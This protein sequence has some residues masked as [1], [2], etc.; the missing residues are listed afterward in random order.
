MT[1]QNRHQS[2]KR[3]TIGFVA[4]ADF[5]SSLAQEL[6][7][8]ID[9]AA[10]ELDVN[11]VAFSFGFN[12]TLAN[13]YTLAAYYKNLFPFINKYNIDALVTWGST[14]SYIMPFEDVEKF[15]HDMS[16]MP[17]ACMGM[18]IEGVPSLVIDN[19]HGI[20]LLMSHLVDVHKIDKIGFIG[21]M[22]GYNHRF[23][24]EERFRAYTR[25]LDSREINGN[26]KLTYICKSL[27]VKSIG[28]AVHELFVE[29]KLKPGKDIQAILTV[30]DVVSNRVSD[31]LRKMGIQVPQD[32][33]VLG[34]NNTFEGIRAAPPLTTVDPLYYRYGRTAIEMLLKQ[35]NGEKVEMEIRMPVE[36][37]VRESCG[38]FENSILEI[39]PAKKK[40]V[41]RK[42]DTTEPVS[43]GNGQTEFMEK[44]TAILRE[45]D[46]SFTP[47]LVN[48]FYNSFMNDVKKKTTAGFVSILKKYFFGYK[49]PLEKIT[50]LHT[51]ITEMR[52]LILPRFSQ[53]TVNLLSAEN[54]FH[55]AR[56]MINISTNY[57]T[58]TRMKNTYQLGKL[59]LI[60]ADFSSVENLHELGD[61][62]KKTIEEF[63][64]PGACVIIPKGFGNIHE[65][66][67]IIMLHH[68]KRMPPLRRN[69]SGVAANVILPKR[70]LPADRYSVML[71][72]CNYREE[73]AGYIV[74]FMGHADIPMYDT[75]R[76]IMSPSLLRILKSRAMSGS[77]QKFRLLNKILADDQ[78]NAMQTDH[79]ED[80]VNA[81]KKAG[82][83]SAKKI[84]D[85]LY[86]YVDEVADI[87][88]FSAYLDVSPSTLMR[89]TKLLTNS[90]VQKLHEKLKMEKAMIL[91]E[92][93][94]YSISEIAEKLGFSTQFYFSNVFKKYTGISPTRWIEVRHV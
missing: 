90:T 36:F 15:H 55:Q 24:N 69:E 26:D 50:T 71:Q 63:E 31:L 86:H 48:D 14:L 45:Y 19:E 65:G 77:E 8:G 72:L 2:E 60:A 33:A 82:N 94:E 43:P 54:I 18:Q 25:F 53:H 57:L 85:C 11:L 6:V 13:N 51:I 61:L 29:R 64:I 30:S 62:F 81:G 35:L 21:D 37:L 4:I 3:P 52:R 16:I 67:R 56:V 73:F 28:K 68:T 39:S 70:Y 79:Q 12:Y 59:A 87:D 83:L 34:F 88:K 78:Q 80:R 32:I 38:C 74:F 49:Y 17:I 75:L 23:C 42:K 84:I 89:K 66:G 10:K 58:M 7:A 93:G 9:S 92:S 44:L 47:E 5:R 76:T 46:E 91:L 20:E 22:R 40:S 1:S 27:D 41:H